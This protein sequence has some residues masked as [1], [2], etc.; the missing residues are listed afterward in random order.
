MARKLEVGKLV[1]GFL[2]IHRDAL[3]LVE[4]SLA[5][6]AQR[7]QEIVGDFEWNVAKLSR[8]EVS[9][10][11]YSCFDENGFPVLLRS[12]KIK[13]LTGEATFTDF[14]LRANPP[15]LHRKELL[16]RWDDAR[17][18]KFAGL[19]KA[20]EDYGLF[21]N[22]SKIGTRQRWL[23]LLTSKGLHVVGQ[24]ILPIDMGGIDVARHKTAISRNDLSQPLQLALAHG[25]VSLGFSVFDYGC[26]L[27]DDVAALVGAGFEAFGWDPHYAQNGGRASADVVN[28]G[29][30]LNVIEDKYE[31]IE[32]LHAAWSF[33]R[34]AIVVSTMILGKV[35]LGGLRPYRDGYVTSRGTFQKYFGQQEL[36]DFL[37]EFVG[38]R[39]IALGPGIFAIF[40]DKDLEQEVLF[41]RQARI[42]ARPL[43]I[44][45]P[46]RDR[47]TRGGVRTVLSDRIRPELEFL[48]AA[49]LERGRP[50]DALEFPATLLDKLRALKVAPA[51]ATRICLTDLFDQQDLALSSS[52]RREELLLNFAMLMF[53]GAPKYTSLAKSIQRDVRHFFGSHAVVLDEARRFVFS[54][55]KIDLFRSSVESACAAGLGAMVDDTTF[56]CC[57]STFGRLPAVIRLRILCGGLL[58]GG[59]EAADFVDIKVDTSKLSFL[60][61]N[62]VSAR[63]PIITEL[64]RVDLSRARVSVERPDG[65]V[66]FLKGRYLPF[67]DEL[68]E[69][70]VNFDKRLIASGLVAPN[71]KGPRISELRELLKKGAFS[72]KKSESSCD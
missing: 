34:R 65:L 71:G 15:I 2:Y 25:V 72:K 56:R 39:P 68:R 40:R 17:R 9:L 16:L 13:L 11:Q 44:R 41:R 61:C 63:F 58:R 19:T 4:A 59:I 46:P 43:G 5:E 7:C 1:G 45:P 54:A 50:L 36:R 64:A 23:A 52:R 57:M 30:V 26:G 62:E 31:R 69:E 24:N 55:G 6:R 35:D 32:T 18:P 22:P 66:L 33:A 20:A 21:A 49:M 28:L 29:F 42:V 12:A 8:N 38:E 67:D 48:W 27:G 14:S 3:D 70:Q 53:P 10:L 60:Q 51:Q 47:T 37:E